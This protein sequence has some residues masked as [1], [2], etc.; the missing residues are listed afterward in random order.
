MET[1][2][3]TFRRRLVLATGVL[4][5]V[6]ASASLAQLP[7]EAVDLAKVKISERL[8]SVDLD[9]VTHEASRADGEA[10]SYEGVDYRSGA[11]GSKAKFMA[12]PAEHAQEAARERWIQNFMLA[13][14]S[15]WCPIT[16]EVTPG[17]R[18]QV[19]GLGYT[20]E[21]CCSFCDEEMREENFEEALGRLR[22]RAEESFELTAGVYVEGAASPVEG[23][24]RDDF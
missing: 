13:M 4:L 3:P 10:W 20:W 18:K 14:S 8:D 6:G 2:A 15:I 23:A 1:I 16:D 12:D 5:L 11:A 9:P 7:P 19:E 24:I 22:A 21:S 17:G